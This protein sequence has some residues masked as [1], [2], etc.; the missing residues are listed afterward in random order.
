MKKR[1][2]DRERAIITDDQM[3]EIPQRG[4][5]PLHDLTSLVAPKNAAIL[6]WC[7]PP[8]QA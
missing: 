1:S 2:I 4:E 5:D 7:P 6:G 3:A 8:I